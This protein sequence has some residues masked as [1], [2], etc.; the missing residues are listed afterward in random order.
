MSFIS[1]YAQPMTGL[2]DVLFAGFLAILGVGAVSAIV[3]FFTKNTMDK[4]K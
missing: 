3:L 1:S 4:K 2:I